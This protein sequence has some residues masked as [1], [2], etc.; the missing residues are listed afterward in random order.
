MRPDDMSM[1]QFR[2]FVMMHEWKHLLTASKA[3]EVITP[4]LLNGMSDTI[5][6]AILTNNER[7]WKKV[8]KAIDEITTSKLAV[9]MPFPLTDVDEMSSK[10]V[11]QELLV[12]SITK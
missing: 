2:A 7:L 8:Q 6:R 3:G 11:Y 1:D 5:S 9:D 4:A 10:E 12:S